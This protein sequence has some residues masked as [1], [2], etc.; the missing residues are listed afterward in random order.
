MPP[1]ET[2]KGEDQD[3]QKDWE[4]QTDPQDDSEQPRSPLGEGETAQ[5]NGS[6][7]PEQADGVSSDAGD[8][9]ASTD[10]ESY[11]EPGSHPP[12][13]DADVSTVGEN[14][15]SEGGPPAATADPLQDEPIGDTDVAD[16]TAELSEGDTESPSEEP[17]QQEDS[18]VPGEVR[19]EE[20]VA[21]P[22]EWA[23][24]PGDGSNS[25][26]SNDID[27]QAGTVP[28]AGEGEAQSV[29]SP[30][31]PQEAVMPEPSVDQQAEEPRPAAEPPYPGETGEAESGSRS[32]LDRLGTLIRLGAGACVPVVQRLRRLSKAQILLLSNALLVASLMMILILGAPW[33]TQ[34]FEPVQQLAD[35][36]ISP[37]ERDDEASARVHPAPWERPGRPECP[38]ERASRLDYEYVPEREVDIRR[39]I[40]W[41]AAERSFFGKDYGKAMEGYEAL[42]KQSD[43]HPDNRLISDFL[44][45]RIAQCLMRRARRDEA[46][47]MYLRLGDSR[48][49]IIRAVTQYELAT[50]DL[51]NGQFIRARTRGYQGITDLGVLE[52][53]LDLEADFDF[54]IA[55]ALTQKAFEYSGRA[56]PIEWEP[57]QMTDPFASLSESDLRELLHR[58]VGILDRS[59]LGPS[60]QQVESETAGRRFAACCTRTAI[61]EFLT[62]LAGRTETDLQ[63]ESVAPPVRRRGVSIHYSQVSQ[64]RLSEV[65]CGAVGLLVRFTGDKMLVYNPMFYKTLSDQKELIAAEAA[66]AWRRW[67]LRYGEDE[68]SGEAHLG[69]AMLQEYSGNEMAAL[70]EFQVVAQTFEKERAAAEALLRS[71]MIRI[72][73]RDYAGAR[74]DLMSLLDRYPNHPSLDKVYLYLA[75]ATMKSGLFADAIRVYRKLYYLNLTAES[76]AQACLGAAR[77]FSKTKNAE[78]THE[79]AAR[80]IG[81]V[82]RGDENL[83]EAY[84]LLARSETAQGNYEEALASYYHALTARPSV[85]RRID[86]ILELADTQIRRGK[87]TEAAFAIK[88]LRGAELSPQQANRYVLKSTE[89]HRAIGLSDRAIPMLRRQLRQARDPEMRARFAV[90]LA[91]CYSDE[92]KLDTAAETLTTILEEAGTGEAWHEATCRLAEISLQLARTD[93]AIVLAEGLLRSSCSDGIRKRAQEVL[94]SGYISRR[95]Y[96]RAVMVLSGL[97]FEGSGSGNVQAGREDPAPSGMERDE[98]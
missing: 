55:R 68:R 58:G 2:P 35:Q 8:Q 24:G 12:V 73:L 71:A 62:V 92:G 78:N 28:P 16:E 42:L 72:R 89:I 13:D 66:S 27:A 61:G 29:A 59:V 45:F 49:P 65:A 30:E 37:V 6:E 22:A 34:E 47:A 88:S 9:I 77:C 80:Y 76:R 64:Q 74:L 83:P 10:E 95:D 39:R 38:P 17:S 43:A 33:G 96:D 67:F 84:M 20:E 11:E 91:D 18:D 25:F 44:R 21:P 56:V 63:W 23:K 98:R 3:T 26:S 48:S 53:P 90:C 75:N 54:L 52:M 19:L 1:Q 79:W 15:F 50:D 93:Q 81:L 87:F 97:A 51:L 82:G 7:D 40:S 85:S 4:A 41:S 14:E 60:V 69:L 5:Q 46:R 31:V 86:A 70:R 57:L 94:G 32:P 36:Q